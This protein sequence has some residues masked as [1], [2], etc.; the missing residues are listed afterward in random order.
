MRWTEEIVLVQEE[1]CRVSAYLSWYA[2]WRSS[3]AD[4]GRVRQ[5]DSFLSEGLEAYVERQA[6]L[7]TSLQ[8]HFQELWSDVASWVTGQ[9]VLDA[10]DRHMSDDN[11]GHMS[12]GDDDNND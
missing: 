8:D 12:D 5:Y 11:N 7:R 4:V 9:K 3:H 10:N 2:N 1:M 6:H